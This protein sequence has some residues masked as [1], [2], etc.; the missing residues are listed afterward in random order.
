M[1]IYGKNVMNKK[2][3]VII[4]LLITGLLFPAAYILG[5]GCP[6]KYMTGVSCPGCGMTRAV[7]EFLHFDF[8][9]AFHYHPLF[10]TLPVIAI[11]ILLHKYIPTRIMNAVVIGFI[12]AYMG[13]YVIRMFFAEGSVVAAE[14]DKG[15][16]VKMIKNIRNFF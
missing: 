14:P 3:S 6:I 4:I 15:I 2:N 7:I 5:I 16:I 9:E 10:F 1:L 11:L 13:V 8:L 12:A